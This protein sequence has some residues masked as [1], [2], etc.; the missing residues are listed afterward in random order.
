MSGRPPTI[1]ILFSSAADRRL[2]REFLQE[3]GYLV[4]APEPAEISALDFANVDLILVEAPLAKKMEEGLIDLKSRVGASFSFLPILVAQPY[5]EAAGPWLAAGFDDVIPL[6]I[7]KPLLSVRVRTWLRIREETAGRFRALVE[8]SPIGFYRSTPDGRFLYANP[9]LVRLL[10]FSSFAEL[11]QHNLE[12][13]A[14]VSGYPRARFRELMEKE[15][16]VQGFE[17]MW[18]CRDGR[19]LWM[20]EN[21]HAVRDEFGRILYY[22]GTVE[23]VT[24]R[25]EAQ[26]AYFTVVENSLQAIAVLQ[27]GRVVFG[28]PALEQL[29]GRSL[30]ELMA[31]GPA[32]VL[33]MVHPEDRAWVAENM[34]RRLAGEPVPALSEFRFIHKDGSTRWVRVLARRIEFAGRPAILAS[35]VDITAERRLAERLAAV[36]EFGRKLVLSRSLEEVARSVVEGACAIADVSDVS[37]FIVDE[38]RKELVLLAH[39]VPHSPAPHRIPLDSGHGVVARVARTGKMENIPDVSQEPAYIR[40]FPH[41]RSELAIPMRI[42]ERVVGVL[43]VESERPAA[44]GTEEERILT[45]LAD[46]A[47]VALENA[48]LF[49]EL[50]ELQRFHEGIVATLAEGVALVDP[51]DRVTFANPAAARLLGY[52]VHEVIGK[53]WQ[54]FVAPQFWGFVEEQRR[55]RAAGEE[56]TYEAI[57][58]RKDGST[59]PVLVHARPLFEEGKFLGSLVAFTDVS[60][61]KE[62]E[63]RYRHFAEQTEEGFYRLELKEPVPLDLPLEE[64][65]NRL[66][67]SAVLTECN[68]A[69]ARH[70]GFSQASDLRGK[71]LRELHGGEPPAEI[72]QAIREFLKNG[73]KLA[74]YE[75][76]VRTPAGKELWI[77]YTAVGICT[78]GK[79][80]AIW[81]T[82]RDVTARKTA[83]DRLRR[84][85]HRLTVLHRASQEI[86]QAIADPE[87]VY[88]AVHRA[89]AEL[90]PVEAFVIALKRTEDEAEGIYLFDKGGRFP[91]QKIP[92][93]Q[94][95]TWHI[96]STGKSM[97]IRDVAEETVPAIH[98]GT[99]EPVRSLLAVPLKAGEEVIGML[100]TQSYQPNAFTDEDLALLELLAAHVAAALHNAQLLS[101]LQESEARFRRL[102]EN[103]PDLI[104]RYRLKPKPGF[105][106]VNPAA[107]R[108]LGYTP[109]EHYADPDL[110]LKIAHPED[111]P[112]LEAMRRGSGMFGQPLEIRFIHKDGHIIWTEHINIPVFDEKGELAAIEGIARDISLRKSAEAKLR[113]AEARYRSLVEQLPGVVY[114][115]DLE[116]PFPKR[117]VYISP[118]LQT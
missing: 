18:V 57:F 54:D 92:K 74:G 104:Y 101:Q 102:T 68:D 100:S 36:G 51:E 97:F 10:G 98:F 40:A 5:P 27:D 12:E 103:A 93:G 11:A 43:N 28:N 24:E 81:G 2:L 78:E 96:L 13:L 95:L 69:F 85:L 3:E 73:G 71:T 34:R 88:E 59:F 82:Q 48:R 42:G 55:R 76:Q 109:E 66:C 16:R 106:Y 8:E 37:L 107:T 49:S 33:G 31:M 86:I 56:S 46:V 89:V 90:M 45:T 63:A 20:R 115:L 83:E 91:P 84:Q 44:F 38:K 47:A 32:E 61:L 25:V 7:V 53:R 41:N 52:E 80:Q 75:V 111:R 30:A 9:A 87:R 29:S 4:F 60:L 26:Q 105:D 117:T 113:E 64:Q 112:A 110:G 22:E 23:D 58:V 79:L 14:Q 1:G 67:V 15:G 50:G 118:Q 108:I 62:F 39:S 19:R 77:A 70:Y 72:C 21:A 65:V 35:Y 99:E 114:L 116:L 94:G 17:S 6:P